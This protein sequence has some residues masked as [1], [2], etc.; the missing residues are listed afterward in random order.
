[1]P[2]FAVATPVI[3]LGFIGEANFGGA[4]VG[5]VVQPDDL[6]RLDAQGAGGRWD[7]TLIERSLIAGRVMWFYAGKVVLPL[8]LAFIYPRWTIDSGAWWQYLIAVSAAAVPI[9]FWRFRQRLGR[10]PLAAV[11]FYGLMLAPASGIFNFYFQRYSFVAD[12]L[13]YLA[14]LGILVLI[15]A[16]TSHLAHRE[17]TRMDSGWTAA[18]L[19]VLTLLGMLAAVQQ[20]AYQN[21]KTLWLT[22]LAKNPAAILARVNLGAILLEE[23][24]ASDALELLND[25]V[26]YCTQQNEVAGLYTQLGEI[27]VARGQEE[28]AINYLKSALD[29]DPQ[30]IQARLVLATLLARRKDTEAALYH[31]RQ[32][33]NSLPQDSEEDRRLRAMIDNLRRSAIN[34]LRS[35]A[36]SPRATGGP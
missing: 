19:A 27:H 36:A 10:G 24:N 25:G 12:H 13:Q 31:Y 34:G 29:V 17:R 28:I 2:Y 4:G 23:G 32:L 16:G 35:G 1:L 5:V 7:H 15:A 33:L 11:L 18:M 20:F 8:N 21:L 9:A 6:A 3:L 14:S 22:T 26:Q 30:C